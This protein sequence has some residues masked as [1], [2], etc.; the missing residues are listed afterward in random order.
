MTVYVC[1]IK[2]IECGSRADRWCTNCP[3]RLV[4]RHPAPHAAQSFVPSPS[5]SLLIGSDGSLRPSVPLSADEQAAM[6]R[7]LFR[8]ITVLP[9]RC[10]YDDWRPARDIA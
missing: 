2:D 1:P 6:R 8:S 5:V 10:P 4:S 9:E 7:A 3:Q